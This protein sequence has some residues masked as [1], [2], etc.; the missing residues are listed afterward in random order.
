ML[1]PLLDDDVGT[2]R[3]I[4]VKGAFDKNGLADLKF[5]GWHGAPPPIGRWR[6]SEADRMAGGFGDSDA[7]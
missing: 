4:S 6:T 7:A 3:D 2:P 5:V 1:G